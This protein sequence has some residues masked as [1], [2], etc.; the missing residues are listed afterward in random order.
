MGRASPPALTRLAKILSRQDP[1]SFGSKYVPSILA[2]K[3]EAPRDSWAYQV[4]WS[5]IGRHIHVLS[6]AELAVLLVVLYCPW[7]FDIQ[8]QRLL[9][10]DERPHPLTGHPRC[11]PLSLQT[12]PGAIQIAEGLGLL[13]FY[14]LIW[15]H[16]ENGDRIRIPSAWIGDLLLFLLDASGPF[17]VN[18]DIKLRADEF[19]KN[20]WRRMTNPSRGDA[21]LVARHLIEEV[22]YAG[23]GIKT[24]QVAAEEELDFHLVANLLELLLWHARR[25]TI[26]ESRHADIVSNFQAAMSCGESPLEAI[27]RMLRRDRSLGTYQAK[28][29]FYQAIWHR[30]LLVDLFRPIRLDRPLVPQARDVMDRYRHWF[31]R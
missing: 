7:L 1:P 12:L 16:D 3:Q 15:C 29:I 14:P 23:G 26:A 24:V 6:T 19:I 11:P 31:T 18:L 4:Y 13:D 5:K 9:H 22:R 21:A 10:F 17:C 8:E 28:I 30:K 27:Y 25:S 2:T 20:H